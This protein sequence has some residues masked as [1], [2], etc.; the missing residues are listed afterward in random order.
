MAWKNP[1]R[2]SCFSQNSSILQDTLANASYFRL[3]IQIAG[4]HHRLRRVR[5]LTDA[6]V[7]LD[8]AVSELRAGDQFQWHGAAGGRDQWNAFAYKF[9]NH[10]NHELVDLSFVEKRR[11]DAS[12][13]HHPDIFPLS[14]P[15]TGC[16]RFDRFV[17]ELHARRRCRLRQTT[18][19]YIVPDS[20]IEGR[21][22]HAL[23]LKVERHIARLPA[24]QDRIDRF[25]KRIH[26]IV[27]LRTRTVEPVEGAIEPG[28]KAVGTHGDVDD[29]FSLAD[30]SV[31]ATNRKAERL[32]IS[33]KRVRVVGQFPIIRAVSTGRRNTSSKSTC[34]SLNS[35]S[36][37]R[38]L[39]QTGHYP[40]WFGVSRA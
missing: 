35:E 10:V 24:P 25:V 40:V 27:T 32:R 23:L 12:A 26:A 20:C 37:S 1:H 9:G 13:T 2:H 7:Q 31:A 17:H 21:R 38:A 15:Q 3:Q 6:I 29:D 34:R 16:E 14:R 33:I 4:V 30:H 5:S 36:R 8:H 28:N 39:I 11:N 22:S 19:E 18:C